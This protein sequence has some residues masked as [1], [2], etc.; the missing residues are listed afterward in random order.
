MID[1]TPS[2][3]SRFQSLVL[4]IRSGCRVDMAEIAGIL[5]VSGRSHRDLVEALT[6][7]PRTVQPGD[8]CDRCDGKLGVYHTPWPTRSVQYLRFA[9][10]G[11]RPRTTS[12]SCCYSGSISPGDPIAVFLD[13]P[14]SRQEAKTH[15]T[16]TLTRSEYNAAVQRAFGRLRAATGPGCPPRPNTQK[17]G[18]KPREVHFR[19]CYVHPD[20]SALDNRFTSDEIDNIVAALESADQLTSE[21]DKPRRPG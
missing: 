10:R 17:I 19:G 8:R 12:E 14:E 4:A 11:T 2:P 9:G 3:D 7:R 18:S 20:F 6:A 16:V 21:R 13:R 1:T 15:A 5:S